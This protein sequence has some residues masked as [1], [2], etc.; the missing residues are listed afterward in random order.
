MSADSIKPDIA[1]VNY[2]LGVGCLI[3]DEFV[4]LS[5]NEESMMR[6]I[7]IKICDKCRS[8]I[9]YTRRKMEEENQ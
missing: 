2:H 7:H 4:P 5:P 8:A 6:A 3:C 9:L 1:T